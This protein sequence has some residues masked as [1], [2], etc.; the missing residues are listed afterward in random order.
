MSALCRVG[1][2]ELHAAA[3]PEGGCLVEERVPSLDEIFVA[4][5]GSKAFNPMEK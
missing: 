5:V 1:P 3:I 4:Q 2:D